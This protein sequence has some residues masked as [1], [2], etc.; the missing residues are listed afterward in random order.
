MNGFAT[1]LRRYVPNW[2]DS[3]RPGLRV[4]AMA[5]AAVIIELL[6]AQGLIGRMT[7]IAALVGCAAL[8][9]AIAPVVAVVRTAGPASSTH[10]H[11]P[12]WATVVG[13]LPDPALVLDRERVIVTANEPARTMLDAA[14]GRPLARVTRSPDLS[15]AISQ[16]LATGSPARCDVR[17]LVPVERLLTCH[18][19]PL[20]EQG[21]EGPAV[22][23]V[24]RDQTEHERLSRMRADF[25]ANASH[26]LRTPLA[27]LKG[28]I[29]TL[30]GPARDDAAARERFLAI[31]QTD[32][33]RM[34][35][36]VDDLLTLS[37][38]EMREHVKPEDRVDLFNIAASVVSRA[39][40]AAAARRITI[41][42]APK[43]APLLVVGDRDELVQVVQN[44]VQN[45]IKYG[46]DG[47]YVRV[48]VEGTAARIAV[49]VADDGIGIAPEHVPRLTERF[50]RVSAKDSR[51]RGGTGLGLA[52]VKHIVNRHGGELEISSR[53][54]VGSTF[55]VLLPRAPAS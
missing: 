44:L 48:A 16:A 53:P 14:P 37:R 3:E 7:A 38:V 2:L 22:L 42:V 25:V 20:A 12:L 34:A 13:A 50:F 49:A 17:I 21:V 47:G 18:V 40:D 10:E 9:L 36:L 52:I 6:A 35:R 31:M 45:A 54:G 41:D 33:D 24:M 29:E 23:V 32:A 28:F 11:S 51:E 30:R 4:A 5:A 15:A 46:R 26:E 19:M 8:L 1:V 43:A 27:S 55:K 39:G